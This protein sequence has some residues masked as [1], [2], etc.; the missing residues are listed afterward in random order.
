MEEL[1]AE[2][3]L[4][5]KMESLEDC[6]TIVLAIDGYKEMYDGIADKTVARL[7]AIVRMGKG[8]KVILI[9]SETSDRINILC[10]VEPVLKNMASEGV[11]IL[12]GGNFKMHS[13]FCG[14]LDYTASNIPLGTDE[15][16]I[17]ENGRVVRFKGM[18]SR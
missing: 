3:N 7:S 15:Y 4:R 14:N 6:E 9:V 11:G 13:A 17:V 2:L 16:Y 18:H 12:V 10:S 5:K 8:L 1:A